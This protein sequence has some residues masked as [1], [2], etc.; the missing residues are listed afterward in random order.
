[1]GKSAKLTRVRDFSKQKAEAKHVQWK[2]RTKWK[3][4]RRKA[5][6]EKELKRK[7]ETDTPESLARELQEQLGSFQKL[8]GV[9]EKRKHKF[10]RR[11]KDDDGFNVYPPEN[12][13][14]ED[15]EN[16]E[17]YWQL[18]DEGTLNFSM[19]CKFN[20]GQRS[21]PICSS[22][23]IGTSVFEVH[24]SNPVEYLIPGVLVVALVML[25]SLSLRY[26]RC[27]PKE[28]GSK[29]FCNET[30]DHIKD[31]KLKPLLQT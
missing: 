8:F 2:G 31:Q 22:R 3:E 9:T 20:I 26:A 5:K 25:A 17:V 7:S 1:M 4:V 15:G 28:R 16:V 6:E 27:V 30:L 12:G 10:Q 18:L 13:A 29:L 14:E 24:G 21:F 11:Q 19:P 23:E